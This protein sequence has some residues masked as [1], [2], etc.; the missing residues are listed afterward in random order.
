MERVVD[1]FPQTVSEVSAALTPLSTPNYNNLHEDSDLTPFIIAMT[2][3]DKVYYYV[4]KYSQHYR[5][6][7]ADTV[8]GALCNQGARVKPWTY[9]DNKLKRVPDQSLKRNTDVR[10]G[11]VMGRTFLVKS[12]FTFGH[13]T[14]KPATGHV[15]QTH[16]AP[17]MFHFVR[18]KSPLGIQEKHFHA[19]REYDYSARRLQPNQT[20][21]CASGLEYVLYTIQKTLFRVTVVPAQDEEWLTKQGWLDPRKTEAATTASRKRPRSSEDDEPSTCKK[22]KI[23]YDP[24][25]TP[26]VYDRHSDEEEPPTPYVY[27]PQPS[28]SSGKRSYHPPPT[29]YVYGP[30]PDEDQRPASDVDY[31]DISSPEP[32]VPSPFL[33]PNVPPPAS[34]P[35]VLPPASDPVLPASDPPASDS[36]VLSPFVVPP[37]ASDSGVMP[38]P[39]APLVMPDPLADFVNSVSFEDLEKATWWDEWI[40]SV[41]VPPTGGVVSPPA[42][43]EQVK[44]YQSLTEPKHWNTH[45]PPPPI[46]HGVQSKEAPLDLSMCKPIHG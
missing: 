38:P 3:A 44:F 40:V 41:A 18:S 20:Y 12:A 23:S 2:S 29:P 10:T 17:I 42:S 37:P 32:V 26:Y 14:V 43:V 13:R 28:T 19:K 36:G 16:V 33:V 4:Q 21:Y 11:F 30:Q 31:E 22:P 46:C 7:F 27:D 45:Y 9:A 5:K 6:H 24:P 35:V 1:I 15:L 39:P 25:Q 8:K 34:D